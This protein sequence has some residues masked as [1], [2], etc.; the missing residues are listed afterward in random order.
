MNRLSTRSAR[1]DSAAACRRR[2]RLGLVST[3]SPGAGAIS[4]TIS[5]PCGI[6]VGGRRIRCEAFLGM[7]RRAPAGWGGLAVV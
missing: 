6:A 4:S 7:V 1:A 3:I 5:L 2:A